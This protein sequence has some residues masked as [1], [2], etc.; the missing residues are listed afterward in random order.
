MNLIAAERRKKKGTKNADESTRL[1]SER[2]KLIWWGEAPE[3]PDNINE[4][5]DVGEFQ[6]HARPTPV[7]SVGLPCCLVSRFGA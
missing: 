4:G 3:R 1:R 7:P 2:R 6:G 5:T